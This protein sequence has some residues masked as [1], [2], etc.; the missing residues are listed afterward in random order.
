MLKKEERETGVNMKDE[1]YISNL[2][3][4]SEGI[5]HDVKNT[6]AT[7]SG[8]AQL[9]ILD[10]VDEET[11]ENLC[12]INRAA[13]EGG[14]ILDRFYKLIKGYNLENN[15]DLLLTDIVFNTLEVVKHKINNPKDK[16]EVKLRL[17]LDSSEKIY[18]NEYKMR[19]AILNIIL[20]ALEAMEDRGGILEINLFEEDNGRVLE[21]SDTGIGIP[22]ED[23]KYIFD[24]SFTTKGESGTGYGLR[25]SKD[26][27]EEYGGRISVESK[28]GYGSKF[29]IKFP[30]KS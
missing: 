1:E 13:L 6:L 23:Q 5:F 16:G 2:I 26:I 18:C 22:E 24:S 21:I 28:L 15:S 17:N 4:L 9:T 19:Q 12:I 29:T 30:K 14:E 8:L 11:R 25:I 7:I 27:F 20:N 3:D 10:E